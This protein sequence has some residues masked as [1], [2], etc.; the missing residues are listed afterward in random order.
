M[1]I[2]S[3][4]LY[5]ALLTNTHYMNHWQLKYSTSQRHAYVVHLVQPRKDVYWRLLCMPHTTIKI[6]W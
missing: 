3:Y 4:S 1:L 6:A 2:K 5:I